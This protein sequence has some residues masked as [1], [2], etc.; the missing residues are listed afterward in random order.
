MAERERKKEIELLAPAGSYETF[1][2]VLRAGADAVYLGGSQFGA[3]AYAN[4]FREE[5]LLRAIDEAHI[6]GRQV[7]LTVNTLFKEEELQGQLYAYLLPYYEQG[8]DAVIVQDMGAFSLIRREFPGMD[9][10]TSTQM[11][12]AGCEGAAYMKELGASRVVTAR[13]MSFAEIG[14]IHETVDIEIES[15]VHGA[16]CYCYS[17]Q[18]LLSSMLGGRSGNRGRCAQPCRLPYEVYDRNYHKVP[19]KGNYVL[20]PKDLC[21]ISCIPQLAESGV[22]SFK[23]EGR[24]KQAEY[25]AG[26]V[27]V[28]RSYIDGYLENL[29]RA[30][31]EGREEKEARAYAAERYRVTDSD[32]KKLLDMGNRSGFTDGYYF[33]Q[34]GRE[35]ITFEKPNHTKTNERLQSEIREKYVHGRTGGRAEGNTAGKADFG[36]IKEKIKGILRLKKDSPATIEL[37]LGTNQIEQTGDVVQPALKQPLS[38][39]KVESCIQKTGNTPFAFEELVI[40]MEEDVFLP[41]QALNQLRREALETL[42]EAVLAEHRRTISDK[43]GEPEGD[44]PDAGEPQKGIAGQTRAEIGQEPGKTPEDQEP[45]RRE[46]FSVSLEDRG[47]LDE[48]LQREFVDDIYLDSSCYTREEL[49]TYLKEDVLSAHGAAKRVYLILPAVFR[50][51]TSSFYR[52]HLAEFLQMGLDGVVVKSFDAAAFAKEY[53]RPRMELILDHSLY[54]WNQEAKRILHELGPLRDTVPLEL[55][56]REI[57]GRDN[58]GSEMMIYG[59][60]PLMTSAQ[61][62]HANTMRTDATRA[63]TKR[64]DAGTCDR[65]RTVTYLKD[66]YGKYFPVKNNCSECYN[67]IYNTTPLMLFGCREELRQMGMAGYRLAFTIEEQKQV[68]QIL[69]ICQETFLSGEREVKEV[70]TGAYTNGHYKRGVE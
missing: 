57:S 4:N 51:R 42:E 7:Y 30:R 32:M 38:R 18:C 56:R 24:M 5:E 43:N 34:N 63:D 40:D 61:C 50:G 59:Y 25:A 29:A 58:C 70:F 21:T 41:V 47:L 46:N 36:E 31:G 9:I 19:A 49:L 23:I 69:D 54:T 66:R 1:Q 10:H 55:N 48:V 16:L 68:R 13:E 45:L 62:V 20:S 67:I 44:S 6:H 12:V 37:I 28:Y 2:A 39:E 65:R 17:G 33:R 11:T 53:F 52:N 22:Y 8:L 26:V 3:R 14:R 15:F 60:L 35:M 27:S 64:A